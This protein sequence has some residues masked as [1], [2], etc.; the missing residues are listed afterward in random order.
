MDDQA[1]FKGC[2]PPGPN[3]Q[4]VPIS[5]LIPLGAEDIPVCMPPIWVDISPMG[6]HKD[7][8]TS[9]G[10][11]ETDGH[12][13]DRILRRHNDHAPHKGGNFADHSPGMP[14][15]RSPGVDGQHGEISAY[16]TAGNRVSRVPGEL[17][18]S[19]PGIPN[20]EN[21]ED[22]AECSNPYEPTAGVNKGH[23]KVCGEGLSLSKSYLVGS[24]PLQSLTIHQWL[25][26]TN[27]LQPE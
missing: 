1:G 9:S 15:I 3:P 4:G 16:S 18:L 17:S 10:E 13:S 12:S 27:L 24:T 25:R 14:D 11:A 22:T 8:E 6:V 5:P 21:E 2:I 19:T 20:S 7:N 26:W 23:S